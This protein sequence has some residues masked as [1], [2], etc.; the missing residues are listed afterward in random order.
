MI[1][2]AGIGK[3]VP[4][5]DWV[6]AYRPADLSWDLIAGITLASFVL[7]E[8]MAYASLAGVPAQFGIYCCIAGGLL[9]AIFTG[10]RQVAVGPTSAIS[11]M[12]GATVATIS[13]GDPAK[14]IAIASL[15][16]FAVFIL[17]MA[18]YLLRLSGLINFISE[19]ILLGFKAG[20]ALSIAS[21]QL[22]VL[23]GVNSGGTNFFG[24]VYSLGEHIPETN[25]TVLLFGLA[26]LALLV[27]G[28]K[29]LT[30]RPVSLLI[31][32][33]SILAVTF[34][35]LH[36]AGLLLVGAIPQGLPHIS[37]PS[38]RFS[39]FD[40]VF[41]LA[42]GCFLVGYV[43]TISAAR[44][45][46]EKNG[47]EVNAR[48]ELLPLGGANLATAFTGGFPVSGGLS[49]STVNDKAGARTPLA[50]IFCSITL[51]LLLLYF[52]GLL[53]NLPEVI[54]G[55][56]VLDAIAGL[57]K[58]KELRKVYTL[59]RIEFAVAMIAFSGVLV[60]GILKGVL[61][62]SVCSLIIIIIR[63]SSPNIAVLGRIP[64]TDKFS[65]ILR[66]PDNK[67]IPGF[68]IFR[69]EA[70]FFYF[71]QHYI[72]SRITDL[73]KSSGSDLKMVILDM[74]SAPSVDIS[75]SRM[76]IKLERQLA[77]KQVKLRI[78]EALSE[79]RDLLRKQGM[80]EMIG[81]ISRKQTIS[82]AIS[83]LSDHQGTPD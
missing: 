67:E 20:A 49:Q 23:F 37:V 62:A 43:E 82:S 56:I 42:L 9:F 79:V 57:I 47:Y 63:A 58:V 17:C 32:I 11:L 29:L 45:F 72:Y 7:P 41:G 18:A 13:G 65:D 59:D 83:Q 4:I 80:E 61:I 44:T 30:G 2:T 77:E 69:V 3:W 16:A 60:F 76:L 39:D 68:K 51:S 66:H 12:V 53:K 81:H 64:G 22:P 33:G 46:A 8:S 1:N 28:N 34:T 19:N 78:V 70:A 31:V 48:Q 35:P 73:I 55:V 15:T 52:T 54:L 27:A 26:A 38:M 50:L 5:F 74:S 75:G 10:S 21:T 36:S 6:R 24:R 14:W 40:D 71:N 25:L